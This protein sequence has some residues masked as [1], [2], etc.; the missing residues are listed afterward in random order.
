[1][2]GYRSLYFSTL[3]GTTGGLLAAALG[4]LLAIPLADSGMQAAPDGVNFFCF[5]CLVAVL[6]FVYFD[7]A[8]LGR[9][10]GASVG[11]GLL[12]G[13]VAGILASLLA[14]LLRRGIAASSP[15]LY[16]LSV[17]ALCFSLIG[18]AVGLRWVRSNRVRLL[19]AYAGGLVGGL[20]GGLLFVLFAPH[21]STGISVA[22]LMLAGA[23]TGFGTGIAPILVRE[24]TLRFISSGDARAQNKLGAE[25]HVW[26]LDVDES[27]ILGSTGTAQ[28]STRFQQGADI[29]IPDA[30]I[31][32]K[33]AV[34]F[35]RE[36]RYFIARH[37]DVGGPEGVAR[38]ILR[39]RGKTVV[40]SQELRPSD[41][42][43][44][45]R[46]ALRFESKTGG[47]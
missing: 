40:N 37:P 18:L 14:L 34:V 10:R 25:R 42:I 7:R 15:V 30:A 17:W 41:D 35:S 27:Y 8:L 23:G 11:Y 32:P 22:G 3:V 44:I 36:G 9:L 12:F 38:Y 1:M 2:Y 31:A 19:H 33:H 28:N 4:L 16:R 39:T 47:H 6:L 29:A 13:G 26:N 43:L 24:G 45:G 46:T 21:V 20:L 5:G